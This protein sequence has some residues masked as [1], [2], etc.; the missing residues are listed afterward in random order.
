MVQILYSTK[1]CN[2]CGNFNI[3]KD[4]MAKLSL[5]LFK[6]I[7]FS[8]IYDWSG[9]WKLY[10]HTLGK[11]WAISQH[12][13]T[14]RETI[15]AVKYFIRI[16]IELKIKIK[17]VIV[18]LHFNASFSLSSLTHWIQFIQ[19]TAEK[20]NI[21]AEMMLLKAKLKP[22][23]S[24]QNAYLAHFQEGHLSPLHSSLAKER[25]IFR[26]PF[27]IIVSSTLKKHVSK[28]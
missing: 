22:S 11:F 26:K 7:L 24:T 20:V 6:Q 19:N 16:F 27:K 21:N 14:R 13:N 3:W 4:T 28:M 2:D 18:S 8:L 17:N 1:A 10:H 9:E 25:R 23:R 5:S 12:I 15:R